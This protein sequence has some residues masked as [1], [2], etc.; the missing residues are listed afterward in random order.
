MEIKIESRAGIS[1][2]ANDGR[3]AILYAGLRSGLTLPYDCATGTCGMCKARLRSGT[4]EVIWP[5]APALAKLQRDKGDILMCQSRATSD[6]VLRVPA[7]VVASD[8]VTVPRHGMG[9]VKN[10]AMLTPDVMHFELELASPM[11]FH[12]GQFAVLTT[13]ELVG[14]RAYSMV[15]HAKSTGTLEFVIKKKP[16]GGLSDWMFARD[17]T[18]VELGIFGPLGRAIFKP[19]EDRDLV[20]IAG[21]SGIAGILSIL[22]H[23]ASCNH[24]ETHKGRVF[25]G[26]RTLA[27]GFYLDRFARLVG[28]SKGALDVVLALSHETVATGPHPQFGGIKIATGF[29]HDV[30]HAMLEPDC[31]AVSSFVEGPPPMVDV[32]IR[33]LIGHGVPSANIRYDKF[34]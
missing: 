5:D 1:S 2:F 11:A 28:Q 24:F 6:C 17:R 25:F 33:T 21:G 26:V 14:G 4:V 20:C 22:E 18:G 10:V 32:A 12:A 29:V 9:R 13:P 8:A 16:A 23:A 34:G 7:N 30:A 19:L 15:N 31:E 3:E 27:D